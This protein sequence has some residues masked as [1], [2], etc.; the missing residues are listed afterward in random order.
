M[1]K[2]R[3]ISS[4]I[5][6]GFAVFAVVLIVAMVS[7]S[8]FSTKKH[9][10]E[11]MTSQ[12]IQLGMQIRSD[13]EMEEAIAGAGVLESV[14]HYERVDKMLTYLGNDKS[15]IYAGIL[16]H[17][18]VVIAHSE[19][20]RIGNQYAGAFDDPVVQ[21]NEVSV[22]MY[23]DEES[24]NNALSIVLPVRN[25]WNDIIG[26]LAL[27]FSVNAVDSAIKT[28]IYQSVIVGVIGFVLLT[29]ASKL[30]LNRLIAP[31]VHLTESADQASKGDF[32]SQ[33]EI[34]Q[35]NEIGKLS[36]AFDVMIKDLKAMINRIIV[37][38]HDVSD[39]ASEL[40]NTAMES[41]KISENMMAIMECVSQGAETQKQQ[42]N[43][44]KF[45]MEDMNQNIKLIMDEIAQFKEVM[46][47]MTRR[48]ENSEKDMVTMETQ[49]AQISMTSQ[50]SG[51]TV[52]ELIE[53][54][55]EIGKVID[56][57]SK[58]ANQTNLIALNA[59]IEAASAGEHGKGFSVVAEEIRKLASESLDA[60]QSIAVVIKD[61]QKKSN[62]TIASIEK[63]IDQSSKG[64]EVSERV[65][66]T[67]GQII[68]S[69]NSATS[70]FLLLENGSTA[71]INSSEEVSSSIKQIYSISEE[72]VANTKEA[73]A[74]TESQNHSTANVLA[75]VSK[76]NELSY[77][78]KGMVDKFRI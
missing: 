75:N 9:M 52:M 59:A 18:S 51:E 31:V 77:S 74:W 73:I 62:E 48:A 57:I 41:K 5:I 69:I 35:N 38:T 72:V 56:V 14:G 1:R 55:E 4:S 67:F 17:D 50:Q 28:M 27:G 71:L 13:L 53:A 33:V 22:G 43:N 21:N 42:T 36:S 19:K 34:K 58:I 24:Q 37:N 23:Y 54:S 29:I 39:S 45:N 44:V 78:M 16:N 40:N 10:Y 11:Q 6:M 26:I 3:S 70:Q 60:V 61:T 64:L 2:Y 63:T 30:F 66:E 32:R 47:N 20:G 76:L 25:E 12:G 8:A 15:V 65:K 68:D 46:E 49:I 7:I